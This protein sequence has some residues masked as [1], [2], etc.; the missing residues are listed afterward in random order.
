MYTTSNLSTSSSD[1]WPRKHLHQKQFTVDP[2]TNGKRSCLSSDCCCRTPTTISV[3]LLLPLAFALSL[4]HTCFLRLRIYQYSLLYEYL[5]FLLAFRPHYLTEVWHK[6]DRELRVVSSKEIARRPVSI[7]YNKLAGFGIVFSFHQ[8]L[9]TKITC[10]NLQCKQESSCALTI[11][12]LQATCNVPQ[13]QQTAIL[14]SYSRVARTV[15]E[16]LNWMVV[17]DLI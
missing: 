10:K 12:E 2:F 9:L 13:C 11:H 6:P 17:S 15:V 4:P 16:W 14:S 5:F 8:P 3:T 1:S 7:S